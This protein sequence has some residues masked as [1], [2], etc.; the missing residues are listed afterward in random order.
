MKILVIFFPHPCNKNQN[1][2]NAHAFTTNTF[3]KY[4]NNGRIM[5]A[6]HLTW[7]CPIIQ[8]VKI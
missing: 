7:G 1:K 3:K 6:G 8:T 2:Q 5:T 4:V